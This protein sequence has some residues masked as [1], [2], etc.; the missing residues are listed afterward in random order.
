MTYIPEKL[1]FFVTDES[2]AK[3]L[4]RIGKRWLAEMV[5]RQEG[6]ALVS[7]PL[8]STFKYDRNKPAPWSYTFVFFPEAISILQ[9]QNDPR[10]ESVLR[11]VARAEGESITRH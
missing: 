2:E 5:T 3:K 1:A 6:D 9:E 8:L 7:I 11:L 4:I 10:L